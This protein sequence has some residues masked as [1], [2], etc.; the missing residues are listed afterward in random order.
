MYLAL[1]VVMEIAVGIE[2]KGIEVYRELKR[3]TDNP[4]LDYLIG[5]EQNHIR[6][7]QAMF[8]AEAVGASAE[9]GFEMPHLDE[10]YLA[11]AYANTDVFGRVQPVDVPPEGL[12]SMA[13]QMEKESM[14]FYLE[15]LSELPERLERQRALS[16]RLA[17][18]ER[19]HLCDLLAEKA[20]LLAAR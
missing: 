4:I 1:P 8:T 20:A 17:D 9:E 12:F 2:R 14:R 15:L 18:E 19:Q 13:V 10:D 6:A 5:Q 3:K 11:A 16:R 7:F